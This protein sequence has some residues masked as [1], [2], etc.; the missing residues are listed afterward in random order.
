MAEKL[1]LTMI[2]N[3][4]IE[5]EYPPKAHLPRFLRGKGIQNYEPVTTATFL[6]VSEK[7]GGPVFDIGA[8]IG[9]Y[10][11]AASIALDVEVL[12]FEPFAPAFSMLNKIIKDYDFEI[13]SLQ[14][15]VS[16]KEGEAIFYISSKSDMSNSLNP[17]LREH[18]REEKIST[19]TIDIQ[20][21]SLA[22]RVIKV[23][24]ETTEIDV[25]KGGLNYIRENKPYIILEILTEDQMAEIK[26]MID[27]L[28]YQLISLASKDYL[29]RLIDVSDLDVSGDKRNFLLTPRE[30]DLDH[31]SATNR[32]LKKLRSLRVTE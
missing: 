24:T 20:S 11:L 27:G 30:L 19:T 26:S 25:L 9:L 21:R 16:D 17:E 23:D 10:S 7:T 14:M 4:P 13:K 15:A 32:F 5:F 12:A 6:A 1:K 28:G 3:R 8:N 2:D 18:I 29:R 31:Y 22:P